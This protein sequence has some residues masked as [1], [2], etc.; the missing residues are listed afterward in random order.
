MPEDWNREEIIEYAT[1][2]LENI[3][4]VW[5]IGE[6]KEGKQ[7][8]QWGIKYPDREAVEYTSY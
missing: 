8:F 5:N 4:K 1:Y 3:P 2:A 6:L 7:N